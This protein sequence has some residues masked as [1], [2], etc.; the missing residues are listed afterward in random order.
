VSVGTKIP[1]LRELFSPKWPWRG[2]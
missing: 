1:V 2:I